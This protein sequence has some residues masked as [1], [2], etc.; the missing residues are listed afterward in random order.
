[1]ADSAVIIP[2]FN[3]AGTIAG[4]LDEVIGSGRAVIVVDDG[5]TDGGMERAQGVMASAHAETRVI[6]LGRNMGKAQALRRGMQEAQSI[7]ARTAITL[8]ADGQH[9]ASRMNA[10]ERAMDAAGPGTWMVVGDRGPI[11]ANYPLGRLVGRMLSGLAVRAACGREVGDAACGMRAYRLNE[12]LSIRCIGGRYAWEEEVIIRA[13]WRG[14][15][16]AEV[17]IPVIYRDPAVA[18]SHY[19]FIRDWSEGT[20]VLGGSVMIRVL[21]P[22]AR[23]APDGAPMT[24]LLWPIA[25]GGRMTSLMAVFAAGISGT[26]AAVLALIADGATAQGVAVAVIGMAALRTRTPIMAVAAGACVGW[27]LPVAGLLASMP[28]ALVASVALI[29]R[30]RRE[31]T[32]GAAVRA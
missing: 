16:T 20:M 14:G 9:D 22:R 25:A 28:V 27:M 26:V 31:R 15:R 1:M 21:D 10:F 24:E 17:P 5:S 8:D 2:L 29:S 18:R 11:P 7:G 13:A 4:V 3:H 12:I 19:R 30:M 23:W 6:R 32:A